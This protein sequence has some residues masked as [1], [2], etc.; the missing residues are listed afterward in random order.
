[1]RMLARWHLRTFTR[2]E[3]WHGLEQVDW[4]GAERISVRWFSL[5]LDQ[6]ADVPL[7]RFLQD[8]LTQFVF[9]QHLRVAMGRFDGRDVQRLRFCVDDSGIVRTAAVEHDEPLEPSWMAD[10][11]GAFVALLSDLDIIQQTDEKL[12]VGP[13]DDLVPE[14]G[15]EN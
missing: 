15:T 9:A 1:M 6:K 3:D 11:F 7:E 10:R 4:D 14:L 5:W 13:H 8:L 12:T 2:M